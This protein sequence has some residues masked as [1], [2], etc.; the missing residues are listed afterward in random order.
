MRTGPFTILVM[1]RAAASGGVVA[2]L[3]AS[4]ALGG[5]IVSSNSTTMESGRQ[6]SPLALDQLEAGVTPEAR[7]LELLGTPS[8]SL[9]AGEGGTIY[10]WEYRRQHS[11]QGAVLLLFGGSETRETQESVSVLVRD[12][13]VERWWRDQP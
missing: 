12:G 10:V 11:S 5:C 13:V 6:V 4:M 1:R 7:M 2:A 8:R 3:A 9:E